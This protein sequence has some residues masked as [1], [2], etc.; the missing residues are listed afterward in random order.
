MFNKRYLGLGF[1]AAI[2][3][4]LIVSCA[5]IA[6]AKP[7]PRC[8]DGIPFYFTCHHAKHP[9]RYIRRHNLSMVKVYGHRVCVA[10]PV[11]AP[12]GR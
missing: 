6:S 11:A 7:I 4:V 12:I 5:S 1:I 3:I 8:P 9:Q 2:V 10:H